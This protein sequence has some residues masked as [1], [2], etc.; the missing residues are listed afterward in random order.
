M[1]GRMATGEQVSALPAGWA[2][3]QSPGSTAARSGLPS[4]GSMSWCGGGWGESGLP[5][6][7]AVG[8]LG[9]V[10]PSPAEA[11]GAATAEGSSARAA[12]GREPGQAPP[13]EQVWGAWPRAASPS[14][15]RGVPGL[16]GGSSMAECPPI[17]PPSPGGRCGSSRMTRARCGRQ[18]CASSPSSALWRT[19]GRE[20]PMGGQRAPS[21]HA[22][23]GVSGPE[24][25]AGGP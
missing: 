25:G 1:L 3:Q 2:W 6:G 8:L 10:P 12:P 7:A 13:A 15:G 18:T 11:G 17:S 20:C 22:P 9:A 19:S 5:A 21:G 23:V 16:G 4:V 24:E 14:A